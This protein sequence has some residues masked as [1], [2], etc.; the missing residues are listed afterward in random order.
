MVILG[1]TTPNCDN[2]KLT[3]SPLAYKYQ[4]SLSMHQII[5]LSPNFPYGIIADINFLGNTLTPSTS[6]TVFY[7]D[8][9]VCRQ[10][11]GLTQRWLLWKVGRV[12]KGWNVRITIFH[13]QYNGESVTL[14]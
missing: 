1:C 6:W 2:R 11:A 8:L 10:E 4:P 14:I 7:S 3:V 5:F 12:P 13:Y 9:M